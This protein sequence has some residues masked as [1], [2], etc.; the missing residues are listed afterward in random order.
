MSRLG[1]RGPRSGVGLL[2]A[3]SRQR[4]YGTALRCAA[5]HYMVQCSAV[6]YSVAAECAAQ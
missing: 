5:L 6:L 4:R 1:D 2:K 3:T